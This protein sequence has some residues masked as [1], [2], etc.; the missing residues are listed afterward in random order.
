MTLDAHLRQLL[1]DVVRE[2][3][4]EVVR[5]ELARLLAAEPPEAQVGP[6]A[7]DYLSTA[8]AGPRL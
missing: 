6:A 7:A 4:R 2:A 1:G 8:A 5:E 3:V